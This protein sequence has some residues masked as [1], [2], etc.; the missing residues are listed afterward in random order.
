[1]PSRTQV[2]HHPAE[3]MPTKKKSNKHQGERRLGITSTFKAAAG[4]TGLSL[5]AVQAAKNAGCP[6]FRQNGRCDCDTLL[7]WLGSNPHVLESA[8]ETV[9]RDVE[10]ALKTR[11]DRKLREHRLAVLRGEYVS[12][13]EVEKW[14]AALGAA[15]RK[16]VTQIHLAAPS[17]VGVSVPEAEARLKEFEDEILMQ[18]HTLDDQVEQVQQP[19]NTQPED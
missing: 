5:R 15:I 10:L 19:D 3:R 8:G 7:I 2:I 6:A 9:N 14:G 12:A 1:L 18:L 4:L 13:D 17:V 16:I 11:A